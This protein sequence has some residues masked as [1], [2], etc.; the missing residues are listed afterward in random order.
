MVLADDAASLLRELHAAHRPRVHDDRG[1]HPRATPAPAWGGHVL[2][3]GRGRACV[4][5]R[6]RRRRTGA[7]AEGVRRPHGRRLAGAPSRGSTR[8]TTSSSG[9]PTTATRCSSRSSSSAS[10]KGRHLPGHVRRA[11]LRWLRGVQ[12]G[13]GA[14]RWSVPGSWDRAGVDRGEEL[15]LQAVGVPGSSPQSCTTSGAIS[16]F[17]DTAPTRRGALSRRT[18]GLLDQPW[19]A[20]RGACRSPGTGAGRIRLGRCA[21]QLPE[22]PHVRGKATDLRAR[23][24]PGVA[25]PPRQGHPALSTASTGPHPPSPATTPAP[26]VRPRLPVARRPEDLEVPWQRRRSS[27]LIDIY[28]ADPSASG[29][30]RRLVRTGRDRVLERLHERYERGARQRPRKSVPHDCNGRLASTAPRDHRS[31]NEELGGR[32]R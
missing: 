5:G 14:R 1:R 10:T 15:V 2:P 4:E 29:R 18:S 9:R 31:A 28:G 24:W 8:A 13:V 11:V 16:S 23:F 12:D 19:R 20:S 32:P 7:C 26:A 22:R 3:D 25:A 30:P 6:A 17:R 27:R 21:R